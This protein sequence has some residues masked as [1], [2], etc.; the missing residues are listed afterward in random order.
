MHWAATQPLLRTLA[1][2]LRI[3]VLRTVL[4]R[5]G[6]EPW[7]LRLLVSWIGA[8]GSKGWTVL[9][10]VMEESQSKLCSDSGLRAV[11]CTAR[12]SVW[13]LRNPEVAGSTRHHRPIDACSV[14]KLTF[15]MTYRWLLRQDE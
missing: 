1:W 3:T 11:L 14:S 13:L 7:S 5:I 8:Y 2:M 4:L 15:A 12:P 9:R 6:W 10:T